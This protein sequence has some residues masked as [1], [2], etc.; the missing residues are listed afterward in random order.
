MRWRPAGS[1]NLSR[2]LKI[3]PQTG[4][5]MSRDLGWV[6]PRRTILATHSSGNLPECRFARV[7]R[8]DGGVISV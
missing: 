4:I 5:S 1:L 6:W 3:G 8:S 2:V 7:V